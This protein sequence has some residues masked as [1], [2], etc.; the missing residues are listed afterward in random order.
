MSRPKP[1]RAERNMGAFLGPCMI[2]EA[3]VTGT[4][5]DAVM[6]ILDT[7]IFETAGIGFSREPT[8]YVRNVVASDQAPGFNLPVRFHKGAYVQLT[9]TNPQAWLSIAPPSQVVLSQEGYVQR[10]LRRSGLI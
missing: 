1:G 9:G 5:T 6:S 8:I 4:G 7:D 3:A 2:D 10:G